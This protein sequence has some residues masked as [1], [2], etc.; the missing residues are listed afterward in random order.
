MYLFYARIQRGG[1]GGPEPPCK[2]MSSLGVIVGTPAK[3]RLAGGPILARLE[4][5]YDPFSP[6]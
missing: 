6:L 5:W 2:I 1:V 4:Y 3:R